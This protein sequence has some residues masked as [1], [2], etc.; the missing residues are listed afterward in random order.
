MAA[1]QAKEPVF[2][3]I[4]TMI[5]MS[6]YADNL[7][8]HLQNRIS[9][10][11]GGVY[12]LHDQGC[13][14][15]FEKMLPKSSFTFDVSADR[16]YSTSHEY[17]VSHQSEILGDEAEVAM[18][19]SGILKWRGFRRISKSPKG[20]CSVGKASHWYEMHQRFTS[21]N[22]DTQYYKRVVPIS[23]S[24][25]ILPAFVNGHIVCGPSAEGGVLNACCS[26]IEDAHRTGVMLASVKEEKEIKFPVP[27][28]DYK[29]VFSGRGGPLLESGKKKAII[30]W[31]ASHLRMKK[32]D[33]PVIVRK[34]IRG[35][36]SFV[37]DGISVVISPSKYDM[38]SLGNK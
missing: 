21:L 23:K 25:K 2:D 5:I 20:V 30:H 12:E 34:H 37:I 14:L 10:K 17:L 32:N 3:D 13:F 33:D 24:G 6:L 38:Q 27:I 19:S 8:D 22:G 31:V 7:T 35:V 15:G 28:D 1:S 29:E 26:L 4:E 18:L 11:N 16:L 9:D 36:Q